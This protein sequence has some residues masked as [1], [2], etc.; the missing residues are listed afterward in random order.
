MFLI[1]ILGNDKTNHLNIE[2]RYKD[3]TD[4]MS[5]PKRMDE[6]LNTIEYINEPITMNWSSLLQLC[7]QYTL[8]TDS[9]NDKKRYKDKRRVML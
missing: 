7:C 2:I 6:I 8:K 1:K 9:L 4:V 5:N 3:M